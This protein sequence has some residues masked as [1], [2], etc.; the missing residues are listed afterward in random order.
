MDVILRE[1]KFS[2]YSAIAE[3][4]M[5]TYANISYSNHLEQVMVERLRKSDAFIPELSIVAETDFGELAGHVLLTINYI[6]KNDQI[7]NALALAPLSVKPAYQNKGIGKKLV[8]E[9]HKVAQTL[10][11]DYIVILGI[12]NYYPKFGYHFLSGYN[13][14]L[15][16]EIKEENALI[17]SL[18]GN[19]FSEISDGSVCYPA[20]FFG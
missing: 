1:E 13:I 14:K 5:A 6:Q 19:D 12:A 3:V 11:Y 7:F 18:S 15:P 4:I 20:E 9:S 16:V 10:G 8:L 2:D 17:I